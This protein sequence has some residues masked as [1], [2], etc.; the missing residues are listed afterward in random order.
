MGLQQEE[1]GDADDG[2]DGTDDALEGDGL[3]EEPAGGEQDD[4]G[5]EGHQGAGYAGGGILH[6]HERE[7]HA[8]EGA[9]EDGTEHGEHTLVVVD[10]LTHAASL[11][12]D[13]EPGGETDEARHTTDH[14]GGEGE[15]VLK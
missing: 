7:P 10:A 13:N 14:V 8:D 9:G 5:R 11:T 4:D 6:S 2:D 3:V 15:G 1:E 12:A